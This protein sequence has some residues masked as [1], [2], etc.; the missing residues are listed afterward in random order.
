VRVALDA[1]GAAG[2]DGAR[3]QASQAELDAGEHLLTQVAERLLYDLRLCQNGLQ[4]EPPGRFGNLATGLG[5]V[6]AALE[7]A[8]VLA[9]DSPLPGRLATLC[10]NMGIDDLELAARPARDLPEHWLSLLA[11]YLRRKPDTV[12]A[13]DGAAASLAAPLPELDGI[14]LALLG[15]HNAES[16]TFLHVLAGGL[17]PPGV[18]HG[19]FGVKTFPVSVW[20]RDDG[21]RWHLAW[22]DGL[23]RLGGEDILRLRLTPP[24]T[25]AT[26]WIEVLAAGRSA[27]VRAKVPLRWENPP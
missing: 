3:A 5:D 8:E 20:I 24:L 10:A 11:H 6:V 16:T 23:H 19:P 14:R 21:G 1:A 15:L 17:P 26:A 22:L 7:A 4:A 18:R 25:R 12:P 9:P 13:R 2:P 27:Q